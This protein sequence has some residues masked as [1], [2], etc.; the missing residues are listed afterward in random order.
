MTH[1]RKFTLTSVSIYKNKNEE[2]IKI[3]QDWLT[4]VH[5]KWSN[6]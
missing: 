1:G 3:N 4:I 6:I 2:D 5:A